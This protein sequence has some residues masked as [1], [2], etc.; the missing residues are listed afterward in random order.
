MPEY[1][2][3][4]SQ[5]VEVPK[6]SEKDTEKYLTER[7]LALGGKSYKWA[8]SGHKGVMDRVCFL[9]GNLVFF[10]EV[11]SEGKTLSGIQKIIHNEIK[12]L[13]NRIYVVDTK[14]EVD[15]LISRV[16]GLGV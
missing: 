12:P 13:F 7:V 9:P 15:E 16:G 3:F 5:K 6:E 14:R 1:F 4:L 8:H 2:K 11:K 10:V